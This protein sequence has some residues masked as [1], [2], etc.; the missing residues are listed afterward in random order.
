MELATRFCLHE[1][2]MPYG[3]PSFALAV[4]VPRSGSMQARGRHTMQWA[5]EAPHIGRGSMARRERSTDTVREAK[6]LAEGLLAMDML[7]A[8]AQEDASERSDAMIEAAAPTEG[9]PAGKRGASWSPPPLRALKEPF[10]VMR[11]MSDEMDGM[12]EKFI[13]FARSGTALQQVP[14]S[15][16]VPVVEVTSAADKLMIVAELPGVLR[17]DIRVEVGN[18]RITIEGERRQAW[19]GEPL[20]P[21]GSARSYGYFFR[22]ID[23]PAGAD[24]HAASAVMRNGML[25]ITVP[26]PLG[27]GRRRRLIIGSQ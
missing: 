19:D 27:G 17:N 10:G 14:E 2:F 23:L 22:V 21:L 3:G 13:R 20:V 18:A 9:S 26:M 11:S 5:Q 1:K 8:D 16:W 24:P 25:E 4:S 15:S 12:V 7:H 6:S